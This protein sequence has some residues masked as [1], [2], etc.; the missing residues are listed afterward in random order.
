ML[1]VLRAISVL[2][3]VQKKKLK[4]NMTGTSSLLAFLSHGIDTK[5]TQNSY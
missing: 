2:K 1:E 4:Q 5:S 3:E